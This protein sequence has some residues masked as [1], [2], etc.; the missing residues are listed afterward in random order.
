MVYLVGAGPGD[1][2]LITVKGR[3]CLERA[4]VVIYDY[5]ANEGLLE[6]VPSQAERIYVGKKAGAHAMSQEEINR[7]IVEKGRDA[8]VVRLKGGDPFIF[9]RG[10]E[11]ALAL[12]EADIPFEVVPGVTSAIAVPAYAGIPLTHRDLTSSVAF[13]TGHE[14]PGKE[15]SAIH[16]DRL[17]TAVGTLVFLMGVRNLEHITS[18]L[19]ACGRAPETPVAVIRW[20][21]TPEQETVTGTLATIDAVAAG[22]SPP[23]IIVV[24]EVAA[25][26]PELNWFEGRPLFGKTILVTRAREQA[27]DFRALLE[28]RGAR[29][30]EFPTIEV[31]PP[32]SWEPLDRALK[33]IGRYQWVIFT[34]VNGVRFL[35]QRLQALGE[36]VRAL[37]GIRLG[38]IGPKTAAALEERGLRLDLVPSE[39]RAEAV[40]EALGEAEIRGRRFLLPRAA[41]AREVLP[42]RLVEM[43]GEVE[44]VTAYETVR[45]SEKAEEVRRLLREG[46]IHCVTFTSS[47]TVENFIAMVG[48]DRLP[49]LLAKA[50]VACIGP[51]TAETARQHGL[52]VEII[53][54][55]YTIEA[56]TAALVAHFQNL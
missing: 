46:A 54:D 17:A 16:W 5:L 12:R 40:I 20:G 48:D 28:E 30:L 51:I 56:L 32:P 31:V 50:V 14:M 35:F 26:R 8:V 22:I 18:Q 15:T 37:R 19:M 36:D 24:G 23:A 29:C 33:N 1:P 13:V 52:T 38:A 47:S 21:T 3:E 34:S 42:E 39:Y 43:G 41:K 27:S 11:E 4:E 45:P 7:L 44:V 53:P 10:G 49:S 25:L 2:G 6:T 9:G 55:E